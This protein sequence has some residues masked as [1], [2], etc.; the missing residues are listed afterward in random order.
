M[1]ADER[2][3]VFHMFNQIIDTMIT[4]TIFDLQKRGFTSDFIFLNDQLFCA[5][6]RCFFSSNEFDILEVHRFD[7]NQI[8]DGQTIVYAIEC[9]KNNIR[10]ILFQ[11]VG[12]TEMSRTFFKKLGKFWK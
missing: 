1:Q 10:G 4:N 3:E 5:K 11:S 12:A 8:G 2:S 7:D 6:T 9:L